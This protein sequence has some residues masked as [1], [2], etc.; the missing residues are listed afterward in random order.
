MSSSY[1]PRVNPVGFFVLI[2]LFAL[3]LSMMF[4]QSAM[5]QVE[6]A[7]IVPEGALDVGRSLAISENRALIGVKDSVFVYERT[8]DAT[9]KETGLFTL[10]NP[11]P[12]DLY[13][14]DV[15][16]EG[17]RILIGA[18]Q[19]HWTYRPVYVYEYVNETWMQ[20]DILNS[21]IP[22]GADQF[23][24]T[25]ALQGDVA[26]VG[27]TWDNER[28]SHAGAVYIF[29]LQDDGTWLKT[30]KLMASDGHANGNFGDAIA[31][32]GD[33]MLIGA[34]DETIGELG[35]SQGA[36]YIFERQTDGSWMEVAKIF[37]ADGEQHQYFGRAVALQGNRAVAGMIGATAA[38]V[39]DR[40]PDGS[41]IQTQKLE[42]SDPNPPL[43]PHWD[44]FGGALAIEGNVLLVGAEGN[45]NYNGYSAGSVYMFEEQPDGTYLEAKKLIASDGDYSND[46]GSVIVMDKG[47]AL[48]GDNSNRAVEGAR[49]AVYVIDM[50]E[51][52]QAVTS[53]TL[54]DSASDMPVDSQDPI[55]TNYSVPLHELP[56]ALNVRA[57]VA[58]EDVRSVKFSYLDDSGQPQTRIEN[59]PPFAMLG[60]VDGDYAE[61]RL[62]IG[63]QF[64]RATPYNQPNAEGRAGNSVLLHFFT[65]HYE[66]PQAVTSFTL[67]NPVADVPYEGYA[68]MRDDL[69][70]SLNLLPSYMNLQ[71]NTIGEKVTGV[72]FEH[73]HPDGTTTVR[74]EHT[75]PFTLFGDVDGN[76]AAG[77]FEPGLHS[78]TAIPFTYVGTG[79]DF[80]P[81]T[82]TFTVAK[83]DPT[84][85]VTDFYL[86]S[87]A[88]G[89]DIVRLY[90]DGHFDTA[91][92]DLD[93]VTR[94]R[95]YGVRAEV[96][97][98]V[99]SVYFELKPDEYTRIENVAPY[100]LYGDV[101][102]EYMDSDLQDYVELSLTATPYRGADASGI[103][104]DPYRIHFMLIP[105]GA[106]RIDTHA[107]LDDLQI[108][109]EMDTPEAPHTPVVF[110][111][112]PAYPNPFNATSQY[113]VYP[114]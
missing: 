84:I 61:G 39:F 24:T 112:A 89:D 103:V 3:A 16:I 102:G 23:G 53:L 11:Q 111:L 107:G 104:G 2:T 63:E 1:L 5:G 33:R 31:L 8:G 80:E 99:G 59:G 25:L 62:F 76:Y 93:P 49:G 101:N 17:N 58:G 27:A 106:T 10:P 4:A 37:A 42:P 13:G 60:D 77:E 43:Y 78:I 85:K 94:S 75:A 26:F 70:L 30:G 21:D 95:G 9:W 28:A 113:P 54:I 15:A 81:L 66:P 20:T 50:N 67:I 32:D 38:Y 48:I 110:A 40:Q 109:E 22:D 47:I 73:T 35:F 34:G 41:W 36:A 71:A 97:G 14:F 68:P 46:Y 114:A 12:D 51:P 64:I 19:N 52:Y 79:E 69:V 57:N 72:R 56:L 96:E 91:H 92:M 100:A 86:V 6:E 98:P 29:T 45:D 65:E 82:I 55:K 18:I 105:G 83:G 44:Y 108:M 88:T 7:R 74:I 90:E 87:I